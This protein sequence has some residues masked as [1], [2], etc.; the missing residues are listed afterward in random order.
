MSD[1][2]A[3]H[4]ALR[5]WYQCPPWNDPRKRYVCWIP[6]TLEWARENVLIELR[7]PTTP[8]HPAICG[9]DSN[10]CRPGVDPGGPVPSE[11]RGSRRG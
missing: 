4:L 6:W 2:E 7:E 8:C 9:A 3:L 1:R 5:W 11:N 10:P